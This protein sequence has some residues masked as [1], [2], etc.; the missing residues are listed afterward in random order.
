MNCSSCGG[1]DEAPPEE[2]TVIGFGLIFRLVPYYF[3]LDMV[4]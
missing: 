4:G 3:I 2:E 1:C